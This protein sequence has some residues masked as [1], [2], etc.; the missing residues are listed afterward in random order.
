[1]TIEQLTGG[2]WSSR[3]LANEYEML[4]N[5]FQSGFTSGPANYMTLTPAD[6]RSLLSCGFHDPEVDGW[7]DVIW[8]TEDDGERSEALTLLNRRLAEQAVMFPP[9]YPDL[10]MAQRRELSPVDP[11]GLR[12]S[13]LRPQNL[14]FVP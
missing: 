11:D 10:L 2:P 9:V 3:W 12:I 1:M 14:T 13:R 4:M 8:Q 7:M 5:T 6:S